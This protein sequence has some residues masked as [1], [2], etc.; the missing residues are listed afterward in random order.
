[1]TVP[2]KRP[3]AELIAEMREREDELRA[4]PEITALGFGEPVDPWVAIIEKAIIEAD[5]EMLALASGPMH[6][7]WYAKIAEKLAAYRPNDV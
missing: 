5:N 6:R 1:M 7:L 4:H 3:I 2:D